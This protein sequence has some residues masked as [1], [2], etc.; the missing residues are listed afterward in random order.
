MLDVAIPGYGRLQLT[1]LVCDFNGTLAVAGE[2]APGVRERLP[3]LATLLRIHVVTG[4][5]FGTAGAELAGS[6]CAIVILPADNQAEAKARFAQGLGPSQV[7]AIGNGRN[8]RLL[9]DAAAL[10]I[11]VCGHEGIA[12]EALQASDIV[13][14]DPASALDLLLETNRLVAT[15]RS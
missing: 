8:D 2:L 3:R 15:L 10:A 11:G 12:S 13:V 9:L 1:E 5:T 14:P 6:P 4:D 7:V